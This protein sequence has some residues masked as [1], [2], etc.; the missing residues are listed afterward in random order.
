[1]D[2]QNFDPAAT[3]EAL[4]R[5]HPLGFTIKD[6]KLTAVPDARAITSLEEFGTL[7]REAK[8]VALAVEGIG[9]VSLKVRPLSA[10]ET[11][12]IDELDADLPPPPKKTKLSKGQPVETDEYDLADPEYQKKRMAHYRKKRALTITKGLVNLDVP[13]D[14]IDAQVDWLA[15]RFP[16]RVLEAIYGAILS[17]STEPIGQAS[18]ISGAA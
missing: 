7:F 2:P 1:M 16:T 10:K 13:G 9:T 6:G 14:S 4:L 12:A 18:F 11:I 15:E 5:D 8:T 17:L 3:V